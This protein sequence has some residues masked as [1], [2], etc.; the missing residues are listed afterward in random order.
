MLIIG[1]FTIFF[2]AFA[3]CNVVFVLD[4]FHTYLNTCYCL[5]FLTFYTKCLY[6][7][8]YLVHGFHHVSPSSS[9]EQ[10][11]YE[12]RRYNPLSRAHKFLDPRGFVVIVKVYW[13]ET[14]ANWT[15]T[16]IMFVVAQNTMHKKVGCSSL[17]KG[18]N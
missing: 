17:I 12:L 1:Q 6:Y 14:L 2:V 16:L 5:F 18:A 3:L 10:C 7:V 15:D 8:L 11:A 13:G 9:H 4:N